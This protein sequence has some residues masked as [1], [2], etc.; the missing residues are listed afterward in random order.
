[1]NTRILI[2]AAACVA[3]CIP[4]PALRGQSTTPWSLISVRFDTRTSDFIYAAY[5]LGDTFALTGVLH[6]PRSDYSELLV[7]AGRRFA[8]ANWPRQFAAIA[9]ARASDGWY[10]QLYV[11]PAAHRGPV[12]VR[13]TS[14]TYIPLDRSGTPQFALSPISSTISVGKYVEGGISVD[15]AVARDAA[16]STAIGP[17]L[18]VAIPN[19]VLGMDAQQVLDAR[20]PR[21][22][23]FFT[24]AF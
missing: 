15:W 7:G 10:A 21:L 19:A 6:N 17:E 9:A 24:G 13:A 5:G 8:I 16:P 14:E 23:I 18:R 4:A 22:R 2:V 20:I 12:W 11:L 1:M 3:A